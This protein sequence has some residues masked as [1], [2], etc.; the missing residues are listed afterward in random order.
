MHDSPDPLSLPECIGG[1]GYETNTMC[2][3]ICVTFA[4][5]LVGAQRNAGRYGW[6]GLGGQGRVANGFSIRPYK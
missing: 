2:C 6:E 3:V 5:T 4:L 1:A